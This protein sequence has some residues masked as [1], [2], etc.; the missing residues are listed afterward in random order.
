MP[1]IILDQHLKQF[2]SYVRKHSRKLLARGATCVR[3]RYHGDLLCERLLVGTTLFNQARNNCYQPRPRIRR[4]YL[5]GPT[6]ISSGISFAI[7]LHCNAMF[8]GVKFDE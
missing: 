6:N 5:R 1:A 3:L 4:V 7:F 8:P 2:M